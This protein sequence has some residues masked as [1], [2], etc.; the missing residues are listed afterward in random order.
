MHEQ[1]VS[2]NIK[3]SP[4]TTENHTTARKP[5]VRKQLTH[6]H[7]MPCRVS[8]RHTPTH[9]YI[10]IYMLCKPYFKVCMHEWMTSKKLLC[11]NFPTKHPSW[12]SPSHV[13]DFCHHVGLLNQ[14]LKETYSCMHAYQ[15]AKKNLFIIICSCMKCSVLYGLLLVLLHPFDVFSSSS[16][17][18]QPSPIVKATYLQKCMIYKNKWYVY[19]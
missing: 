2:L 10:Y 9:T 3:T 4:M 16:I 8:L 11:R 6:G 1:T 17:S 13:L 7:N 14:R 15:K 5:Q 12:C 19:S 18:S